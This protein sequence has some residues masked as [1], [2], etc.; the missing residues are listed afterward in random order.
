MLLLTQQESCQDHILTENIW[1]V[2]SWTSYSGLKWRCH[3]ELKDRALSQWPVGRLSEEKGKITFIYATSFADSQCAVWKCVRWQI[4]D[5]FTR[6][7]H[8]AEGR[9]I[10][11]ICFAFFV[12]VTILQDHLLRRDV[13]WDSSQIDTLV[14]V[15]ARDHEENSGALRIIKSNFYFHSLWITETNW[16]HWFLL[17]VGPVFIWALLGF[18]WCFD[19]LFQNLV[20]RK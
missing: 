9:Q 14:C 13:K 20:L 8:L 12:F 5:N 10:V 7:P 6:S 11:F 17:Y 16:W 2:W 1:F 15:D 18:S 4:C 3:H 19:I